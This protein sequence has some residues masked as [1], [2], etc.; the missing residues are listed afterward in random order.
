MKDNLLNLFS[1]QRY[2]PGNQPFFLPCDSPSDLSDS[3]YN[4]HLKSIDSEQLPGPAAPP[5]PSSASNEV[6]HIDSVPSVPPSDAVISDTLIDT[7]TGPTMN[8]D[9]VPVPGDISLKKTIKLSVPK[10][11]TVIKNSPKLSKARKQKVKALATVKSKTVTFNKV[12][13]V[14]EFW[15][16]WSRD[17]TDNLVDTPRVTE[18]AEMNTVIHHC[19]PDMSPREFLLKSTFSKGRNYLPLYTY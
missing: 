9:I 14:R 4:N 3:L 11:V 5:S 12:V 2:R 15:L 7:P 19:P 17:S 8:N 6:A 10:P 18:V 16:K 1:R 13:S